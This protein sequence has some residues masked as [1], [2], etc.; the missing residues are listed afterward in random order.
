M[1]AKQIIFDEKARQAI[2]AGV[3]KMAE[4]VSVTLGPKGR[5]VAL[6]SGFGS[7]TIINDGVSIAKEIEL[8]DKFENIGAQ[9]MKEVAEKT[10][11]VAGDGT[12][13]AIILASTIVREG[14]K[15][16]TAGASPTEIKVGIEK[17]ADA[18]VRYL[19][20]QSVEVRSKEKIAQVATIS[21]N[22]DEMIGKLIADAM[23][24]VGGNGVITV[25]EAKSLDTTLEVVEGMQFD[26]GFVSPYM[27]TNPDKMITELDDPVIL[28]LDKKIS[29][30]KELLPVLEQVAQEGRPLVIIAEDV[31]GEALATLILNM[32]RGALKAVAVKAPGFGDDQKEM[33]EDIA[34]LT[35]GRVISEDKGMKLEQAAIS[36][37][38][39][40]KKVK[41]DKDKTVIIGGQGD[42]HKLK[43]RAKMIENQIAAATSE[44]DKEDLKKRLAKLTGGVAVINVGAATETEM[45]ERKARVDDALHATRAAVEEGVIAGGGVT[46]LRSAKVLDNLKL[47]GDQ[48]IGIDII[49][50]AIL[51]PVKEIAKNAGKEPSIIADKVQKSSDNIGYNAKEGR[52]EDMFKAGVIDPTKVART[53][54]Q[55]AVSIGGLILITEAV[56]TDIPD[57]KDNMPMMPPGGMGGMGM[58]GMM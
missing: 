41:V 2:L 11:D 34:V 53:A 14:I 29:A 31:E 28:M 45:K 8:E 18:V 12:T 52:F 44:Y 48:Q 5:C 58:P 19:K 50:K 22:N 25:E 16:I 39:R 15:N 57:K 42:P 37:L 6:D 21:A 7:P 23:E 55:N 32:I 36:D 47:P 40:A 9:L 35:G 56:V 27:V 17:A 26:K 1:G 30:M 43:V 38:G 10:Q 49:K 13:T 4:T 20:S 3:N 51:R 33:L 24:K 54:L 46:L